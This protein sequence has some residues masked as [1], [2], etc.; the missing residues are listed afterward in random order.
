[1]AVMAESWPVATAHRIHAD[2]AAVAAERHRRDDATVALSTEFT[3]LLG[4][5][6]PIALAPMGGSAGGALAAAVSRGGG[7]GMLGAGDGDREWL[8]REASIVASG[9]DQPWG[10]GFPMAAASPQPLPW[11][12]PEP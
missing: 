10:V 6:A 7:F 1:M 2:Q 8:D 3:E 4:G 12:L 5:A 9:T 11:A